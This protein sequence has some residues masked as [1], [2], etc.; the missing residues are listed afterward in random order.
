MIHVNESLNETQRKIIICKLLCSMFHGGEFDL[1]HAESELTKRELFTML[2][3][4]EL[5]VR[6]PFPVFT[7][8]GEQKQNFKR[9]TEFSLTGKNLKTYSDLLNMVS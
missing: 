4:N 5:F 8:D 6:S 1:I 3:I 2:F 9:T 7:M